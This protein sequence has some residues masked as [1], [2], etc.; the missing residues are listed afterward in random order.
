MHSFKKK[1]EIWYIKKRNKQIL[2]SPEQHLIVCQGE[3]TEPEYF[4]GIQMKINSKYK[5]KISIEILSDNS[6]CM[7][8]LNVAKNKV[9][10]DKNNQ[11]KYKHVWLVYDKDDFPS[12][13]FDNIIKKVEKI[14]RKNKELKNDEPIYHV[15]WS[16][17]CIEF[18]FL[19]H[20]IDLR[21]NIDRKKYIGKISENFKK[22]GIKGKY[23]KNDNLIYKKLEDFQLDAIKR[24][25]DII[26]ENKGKTPSNI[27]PGTNV[28]EIIEYLKVYL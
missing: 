18:W 28:Y 15:L 10:K 4:N 21:V 3:K 1:E 27:A 9:K 26:N 6:S 14:N 20:F 12:D 24:A 16:N 5:N 7:K 22:F 2:M 13:E 25:K 17:Q 19:L 8:M 11:I 23:K